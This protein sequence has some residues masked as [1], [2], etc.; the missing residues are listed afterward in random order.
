MKLF[1]V[2][3]MLTVL[4]NLAHAQL[5]SGALF[6]RTVTLPVDISTTKNLLHA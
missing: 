2:T 4:T 3:F 5:A 6:S 1:S